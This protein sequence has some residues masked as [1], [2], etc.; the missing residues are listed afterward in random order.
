MNN[1]KYTENFFKYGLV[2]NEVY[3]LKSIVKQ[4][5]SKNNLEFVLNIFKSKKRIYDYLGVYNITFKNE[6][7]HSESHY[8]DIVKSIVLSKINKK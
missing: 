8:N 3:G 5:I 6:F 2:R 4:I 1:I 7:E